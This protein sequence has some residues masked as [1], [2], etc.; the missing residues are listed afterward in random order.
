MP[1]PLPSDARIVAI[2]SFENTA[3]VIARPPRS[4][5]FDPAD[6]VYKSLKDQ[7]KLVINYELLDSPDKYTIH[8]GEHA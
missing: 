1:D 7:G 3:P 6:A 4:I 2:A 8:I 5:L